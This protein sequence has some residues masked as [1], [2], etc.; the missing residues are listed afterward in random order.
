MKALYNITD[1]SKETA[2]NSFIFDVL[3]DIEKKAN[4]WFRE[5][6]LEPKDYISK[7]VL[8]EN[9][10]DDLDYLFTKAIW[11]IE[12]GESKGFDMDSKQFVESAY[13][14][15]TE[16]ENGYRFLVNHRQYDAHNNAL[17]T[18]RQATAREK[19]TNKIAMD[20]LMSIK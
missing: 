15:Y 19:R 17:L 3:E 5:T 7:D 16:K 20:I 1:K 10:R 13:K 9:L 12:M 14:T 6:F 11:L 2:F 8:I 18:K 4:D